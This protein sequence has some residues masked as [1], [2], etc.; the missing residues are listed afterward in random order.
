MYMFDEPLISNSRNG[1]S[2]YAWWTTERNSRNEL[3][4]YAWWTTYIQ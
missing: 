4:E 3:S 2:E 1:L